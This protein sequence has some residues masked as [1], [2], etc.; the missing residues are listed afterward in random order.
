M[1]VWLRVLAFEAILAAALFVSAGRWDLP[2][3]WALIGCHTIAMMVLMTKIDPELRSE[4]F[5]PAPG[6]K[7]RW[8]RLIGTPLLLAHLV[9]AGL[10]VGRFHWSDTVPV[11]LRA[12]ALVTYVLGLSWSVWAM[13]VNRFFAPVVRIQA[14]RG[15]HLI[16][17]GPYRRMRHPGYAGMV[18]STISGGLVLGSWWSLAPVALMLLLVLRRVVLEDRFLHEELGGYPAYADRVRYRLVPGVW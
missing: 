15:H 16:D 9:I 8:L 4:R 10:D 18:L 6:G 14:E 13:I 17:T 12:A 3:S 5:R 7:D 1:S 2:W 11:P